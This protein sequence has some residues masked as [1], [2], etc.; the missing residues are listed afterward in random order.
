MTVRFVPQVKFVNASGDVE[1]HGAV[2]GRK[3]VLT[4]AACMSALKDLYVTVGERT[5]ATL[6]NTRVL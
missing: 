5:T 2:L 1:C 4:S 6:H 3:S